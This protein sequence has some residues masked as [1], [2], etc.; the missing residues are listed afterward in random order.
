MDEKV[1]CC[2]AQTLFSELFEKMKKEKEGRYDARCKT[3]VSEDAFPD[4]PL[5]FE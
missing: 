4:H 5:T 2:I 3:K 1:Q